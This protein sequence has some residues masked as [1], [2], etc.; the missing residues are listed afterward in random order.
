MS[1]RCKNSV[2]W[3]YKLDKNYSWESGLPIQHDF[4]YFDAKGKV[5]LIIEVGGR[6]TVTKGYSWNGCSP[7]FCI[8]DINIGTPDGVVHVG[9]CRPKTYFASLLHDALYQFLDVNAPLTRRQADACFLRLMAD[10]DFCLR[11]L[12]WAAVRVFGRGV[13]FGKKRVRKWRGEAFDM[14][15][16]LALDE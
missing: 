1:L 13:W 7:K 14:S 11:G 12:Y 3:L 8:L 15:H 10:S 16:W 4:A 5:R 9:T 2:S 6:I